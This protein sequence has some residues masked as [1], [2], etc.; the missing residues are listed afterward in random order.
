ML[1]CTAGVKCQALCHKFYTVGGK[2]CV[3][4]N[5][6]CDS[7]KLNWEVAK[8]QKLNQ[9]PTGAPPAPAIASVTA[10]PGPPIYGYGRPW[11]VAHNGFTAFSE[12]YCPGGAFRCCVVLKSASTPACDEVPVW[13]ATKFTPG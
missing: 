7:E 12:G 10:P 5:G 3:F 8:P 4:K 13:D 6:D 11:T 1:G 9:C 2:T